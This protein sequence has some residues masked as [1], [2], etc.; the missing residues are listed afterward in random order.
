MEL[1]GYCD[2]VGSVER[3]GDF[4]HSKVYSPADERRFRGC[5]CYY[6]TRAMMRTNWYQATSHQCSDLQ[7]AESTTRECWP[8]L[9]RWTARV[10]SANV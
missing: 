8:S 10:L 6:C 5:L 1:N 9:R 7:P 3:V 2:G 4:T